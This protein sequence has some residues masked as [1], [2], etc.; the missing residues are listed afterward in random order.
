MTTEKSRR[1]TRPKTSQAINPPKVAYDIFA[2]YY[3]KYMKHVDY[4]RWTDKILQLYAM[5]T[6]KQ[7]HDILE[8]ACGTAQISSRL[9]R[10]GYN[11][12]ASDRSAEMLNYA[13][14]K[15]YKPQLLQ[16][17]MTSPLPQNS[18]ELAI[19]V[20]DSINYLTESSDLTVLFN[21]VET[22]LKEDGLFI[23]DISTY[24][25]SR[26][27]FD[28]Y[29][30]VDEEKD[31]LLIHRAN[32]IPELMLQKTHLTIFQKS[33]NHYI[34]LEEEHRQRVYF[35]NEIL[36]ECAKSH[37]DCAGIYSLVYDRNLL[38]TNT[39]KLDRQ[40]SRLF[41]VLKKL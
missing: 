3:D 41:F 24:H 18:F 5:H 29:L 23:F 8:L 9:V 40:Y 38:K 37:L 26:E 15:E 10:L 17:D 25:N 30:N 39:H 4:D 32:F 33:D 31:Y 35:V 20:F 2:P 16:A 12:T 14:Q 1:P 28:D 27:N 7:L 34:R 11:V 36:A 21:N 22:A 13:A 6:R 19:L